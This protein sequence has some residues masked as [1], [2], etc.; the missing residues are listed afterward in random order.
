MKRPVGVT[1]V[2]AT[3]ILGGIL[4]FAASLILM[5]DMWFLFNQLNPWVGLVQWVP[6]IFSIT[7]AVTGVGLSRLHRWAR[8]LAIFLCLLVMV[9]MAY[10]LV[11][12][13]FRRGPFNNDMWL[14]NPWLLIPVALCGLCLAYMFTD[15]VKQAFSP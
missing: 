5:H 2:A 12:G 6:F 14:R 10:I 4:Q 7:W 15:K 3:F 11:M 1:A 9:D 13:Y 8:R